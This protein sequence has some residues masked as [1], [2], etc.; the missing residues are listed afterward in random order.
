MNKKRQNTTFKTPLL[1]DCTNHISF[2][3]EQSQS[4]AKRKKEKSSCTCTCESSIAD[5]VTPEY[6]RGYN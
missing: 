5:I 1:N 6:I 4:E 2:H 3:L